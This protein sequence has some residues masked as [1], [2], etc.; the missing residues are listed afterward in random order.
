MAPDAKT[1]GWRPPRKKKDNKRKG[2]EEEGEDAIVVDEGGDKKGMGTASASSTVALLAPAS[3][4][5]SKG[6]GNG[7]TRRGGRNRKA[8]VEVQTPVVRDKGLRGMIVAMGK[9]GLQTAQRSRLTFGTLVDAV[10]VPR[11]SAVAQAI[12]EEG[13]A[14]AEKADGLHAALAA[15]TRDTDDHTKALKAIKEQVAPAK[16]NYVALLEALCMDKSAG[17]S[18]V[19][20]IKTHLDTL[21]DHLPDVQICKLQTI[22]DSAS[23]M[24]LM[25]LRWSPVR[26]AILSACTQLGYLVK[27][28]APPPTQAEDEVSAYLDKLTGS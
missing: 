6:G 15:A 24:I 4:P 14:F 8:K 11:D 2:I 26:E 21:G 27:S 20:A 13:T 19:T 22:R 5:Q 12:A 17:G 7:K 18:N 3:S 23:V 25:C 28:D 1:A 10:T 9:M 16:G